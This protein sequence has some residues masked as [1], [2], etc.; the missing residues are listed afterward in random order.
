MRQQLG[1]FG[2]PIFA[3][4]PGALLVLL[5][6]FFFHSFSS[7]PSLGLPPTHVLARVARSGLSACVASQAPHAVADR[8]H[9]D[10]RLQQAWSQQTTILALAA[11]TPVA[12]RSQNPH[13]ANQRRSPSLP[14]P[15]SAEYATL[16]RSKS[17]LACD[18]TIRG[19]CAVHLIAS[20]SILVGP[21][22]LF[23]NGIGTT[24]AACAQVKDAIV[25]RSS[26]HRPALRRHHP[27][28]SML[29]HTYPSWLSP[30]PPHRQD[31]PQDPPFLHLRPH[32]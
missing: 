20:A 29:G 1:V 8:A 11:I 15:A 13:R 6:S 23:Q 17:R 7:S 21:A 4:L 9:I 31:P 24:R 32:H 16:T 3:T 22:T 14:R 10:H 30:H 26:F 12:D 19:G 27:H 18:L 2:I 28:P 25:P 5:C